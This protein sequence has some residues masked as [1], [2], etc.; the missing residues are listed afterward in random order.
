MQSGGGTELLGIIIG[1]V[2]G[3][4]ILFLIF[5]EFNCWY[6]K[7]NATVALLKEISGKLDALAGNRGLVQ[8]GIVLREQIA[9]KNCGKQTDMSSKYCESCGQPMA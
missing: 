3:A 9:C 7:I 8:G 4:I 6:W 2:I 1:I 5:R